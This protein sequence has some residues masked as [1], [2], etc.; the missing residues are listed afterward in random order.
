MDSLPQLTAPSE[1]E[2]RICE[3]QEGFATRLRTSQYY[4]VETTKSD[5][6]HIYPLLIARTYHNCRTTKIFGQVPT[7]TSGPADIEEEGPTPTVLSS[8]DF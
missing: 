2:R 7:L 1:E 6:T 8:R 5:G 4:L 3:L